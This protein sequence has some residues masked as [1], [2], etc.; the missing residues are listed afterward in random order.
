MHIWT[1]IHTPFLVDGSI[2]EDGLRKN[3]E[4]YIARGI[5]GVFCNGLMG[6]NWSVPVEDR[7]EVV[8]ILSDQSKGRLKVC[9]VASIGSDED[10][11]KLGL[12]YKEV[13]LDY[14]CLITPSEPQPDDELVRRF[15]YK[16]NSIDM[17]TVIFNA[18]RVDGTSV[19]TPEAFREL[20]KNPHLRILKTTVS[21]EMNAELRAVARPDVYVSDPTEEKF[22]HNA[23]ENGQR[24]LFADPE[25]VLYQTP[26]FRPIEKY[27]TLIEEGRFEEARAI[28]DA[29]APLRVEY[30]KWLMIEFYRGTR[31][32]QYLKK[33]ASMVGLVGGYVRE[34]L[35]ELTPVENLAME[36]DIQAAMDKV[37]AVLGD[38]L[39]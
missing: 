1:A 35:Q 21:D 8:R 19:L 37:H 34:P 27:A 23:V 25:P 4:A 9:A 30:N 39:M 31:I 24:I 38:E 33:W 6:E 13:G 32:C 26:T 15:D 17:P 18:V 10:T 36:M 2:D 3:V 7:L 29:L 11:I 28:F 22:F 20:N 12:Q 16:M 14:V 5:H